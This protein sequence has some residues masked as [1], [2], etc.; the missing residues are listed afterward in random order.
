MENKQLTIKKFR[1]YCFIGGIVTIIIFCRVVY[2]TGIQLVTSPQDSTLYKLLVTLWVL[3]VVIAT[4]LFAMSYACYKILKDM[5]F[6]R[7]YYEDQ[8]ESVTIN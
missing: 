2:F 8:E 5:L 6:E 1:K 3:L 4:T 7:L